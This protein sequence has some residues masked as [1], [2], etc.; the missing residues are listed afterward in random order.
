MLDALVKEATFA[1]NA[2]VVSGYDDFEIVR[3]AMKLGAFDYLLKPI[4]TLE[5]GQVMERAISQ[6]ERERIDHT[7]VL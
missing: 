6:L 1:W 4:N 2:V 5:L 7:I 3:Q